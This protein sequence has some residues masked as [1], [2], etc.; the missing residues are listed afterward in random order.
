MHGL[1]DEFSAHW[2][3]WNPPDWSTKIASPGATSRSTVKPS[4][5]S[6]TDSDA[7]TYSLPPIASCW[8]MM[9]GLIPNGSRKAS[10]P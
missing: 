1:S 8:P 2:R 10:M 4:G 9:S 5:S 6:A 7:T 3:W